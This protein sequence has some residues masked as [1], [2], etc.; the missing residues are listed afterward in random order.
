MLWLSS[1]LEDDMVVGMSELEL[2][3]S[4]VELLMFILL[5]P[6]SKV[7]R[8]LCLKIGEF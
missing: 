8:I 1:K 2:F 5:T 4:E 3:S 6:I 7:S